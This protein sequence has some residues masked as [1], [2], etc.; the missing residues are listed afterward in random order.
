MGKK[1]SN[2]SMSIDLK[3]QT[4]VKFFTNSLDKHGEVKGKN[5][6]ETK[7]L[8]DTCPHHK[9]NKKGKLRSRVDVIDG[10]AHCTMCGHEFT[11]EPY[12]KEKRKKIVKDFVELVDQTEFMGTA[13]GDDDNNIKSIASAKPVARLINDANKKYTK[14]VAKQDKIKNKKDKNK[15]SSSSMGGWNV[16]R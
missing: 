9:L 8:R 3:G 5:K 7:L 4:L 10:M 6:K 12:S 1:K 2:K 15:N 16:R 14:L 11:T 13:I